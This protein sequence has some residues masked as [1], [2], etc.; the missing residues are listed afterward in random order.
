[1]YST[2]HCSLISERKRLGSKGRDLSTGHS[3]TN[4]DCQIVKFPTQEKDQI[5]GRGDCDSKQKGLVRTTG[6]K[7]GD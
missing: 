7:G 4:F 3:R 6:E 2:T 5:R 1:M